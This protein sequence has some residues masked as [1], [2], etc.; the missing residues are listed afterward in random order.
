[1]KMKNFFNYIYKIFFFQ[2]YCEE[3]IENMESLCNTIAG[4][5]PLFTMFRKDGSLVKCPFRGPHSFSYSKGDKGQLCKYPA[6]YM[7]TCS[8]NKRLQLRYQACHDVQGS[9]SSSKFQ[10]KLSFSLFTREFVCIFFLFR[11]LNLLLTTTLSI[12][13]RKFCNAR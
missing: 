11:P 1:M 7:D 10:Y 8:D 3:N 2:G 9:E 13:S 12:Q 6:S 4:D 5:A